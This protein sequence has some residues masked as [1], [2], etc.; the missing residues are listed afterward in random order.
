MRRALCNLLLLWALAPGAAFSQAY[1]TKPIR[2]VVPYSSGTTTDVLG[3][4]YAQKL[5]ES[6]GQP[7]I[8]ENRAGAGGN[9]AGEAVATSMFGAEARKVT[10]LKSR[11]ASNGS[12]A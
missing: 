9:I 8:V 7:V 6:L 10:W 2:L 1:P 5:S 4:L 11:I 3:R 12:L